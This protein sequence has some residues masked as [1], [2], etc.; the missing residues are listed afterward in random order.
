MVNDE[1]LGVE[2]CP[3]RVANAVEVATAADLLVRSGSFAIVV[4]DLASV[5]SA[6]ARRRYSTSIT[7]RKKAPSVIAPGARIRR[8]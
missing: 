4:L 1:L 3:Q 5:E 2:Q 8:G 7:A 6:V